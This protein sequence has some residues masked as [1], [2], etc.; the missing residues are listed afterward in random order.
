M[1][2]RMMLLMLFLLTSAG[3]TRGPSEQSTGLA[4]STQEHDQ[5]RG[6]TNDNWVIFQWRGSGSDTNIYTKRTIALPFT[7][8]YD[9]VGI[10]VHVETDGRHV[11]AIDRQEK[12]LWRIDPFADADLKF[13]RTRTPR[14]VYVADKLSENG[15]MRI[16]F[17]S[18]Q[19]VDVNIKTGVS[20]FGGQD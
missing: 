3:C 8:E 19:A 9:E 13:Y 17:D 4:W 5:R 20:T 7:H 1:L 2:V 14:I 16:I 15:S 10:I 18:S 12:T 6:S 11:T